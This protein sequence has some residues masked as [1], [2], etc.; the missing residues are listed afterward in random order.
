MYEALRKPTY[1]QLFIQI[2]RTY[3]NL[4]RVNTMDQYGNKEVQY[5]EQ[6][7]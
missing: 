7:L 3:V 4:K 2:Y 1:Q 5:I 6:Q